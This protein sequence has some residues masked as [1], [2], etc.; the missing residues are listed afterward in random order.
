MKMLCPYYCFAS[1]GKRMFIKMYEFNKYELH[2]GSGLLVN[3]GIKTISNLGKNFSSRFHCLKDF[4]LN[5]NF[6]GRR[7]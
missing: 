3:D 7:N 5:E 6:Y 4:S 1:C 2:F